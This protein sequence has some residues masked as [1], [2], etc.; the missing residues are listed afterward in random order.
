MREDAAPV[1]APQGKHQIL[2]QVPQARQDPNWGS[3]SSANSQTTESQ[4]SNSNK[5]SGHAFSTRQAGGRFWVDG[6][7]TASK[8][9]ED[10]YPEI[11]FSVEI[12]SNYS[13]ASTQLRESVSVGSEMKTVIQQTTAAG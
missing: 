3:S 2:D 4:I 6:S 1:S 5:V 8:K 13:K 9:K 12:H 11:K 7:F 10:R